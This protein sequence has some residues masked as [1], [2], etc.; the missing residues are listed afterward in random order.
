MLHHMNRVSRGEPFAC[1]VH[2]TFDP[3]ATLVWIVDLRYGNPETIRLM[4]RDGSWENI[5]GDTDLTTHEPTWRL[6]EGLARVLGLALLGKTPADEQLVDE[7]RKSRDVERART[8]RLLN[9]LL[10]PTTTITERPTP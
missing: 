3:G 10:S 5:P 7:L 8:D 6:D 4:Q 2:D 9:A 1:V